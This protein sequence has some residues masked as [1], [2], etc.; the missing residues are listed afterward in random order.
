[1]GRSAEAGGSF[2]EENDPITPIGQIGGNLLKMT[3]EGLQSANAY[4]QAASLFDFSPSGMFRKAATSIPFIVSLKKA[5]RAGD[6]EAAAL[7]RH[8]ESPKGPRVS[9]T[10]D[11]ALIDKLIAHSEGALTPEQRAALE[12]PIRRVRGSAQSSV[13]MRDMGGDTFEDGVYGVRPGELQN[14]QPVWQTYNV[15]TG[16]ELEPFETM[17]GAKNAINSYHD[18]DWGAGKAR[19]AEGFQG[20]AHQRRA[21]DSARA[22]G[23]P[24]APDEPSVYELRPQKRGEIHPYEQRAMKVVRYGK[25]RYVV[26]D[27][28]NGRPLAEFD[29]PKKAQKELNKLR[30]RTQA[31]ALKRRGTMDPEK[32]GYDPAGAAA[33]LMRR[34]GKTN[35]GY[36]DEIYDAWDEAH[37]TDQYLKRRDIDPSEATDLQ[38]MEAEAYAEFPGHQYE[39]GRVP[40]DRGPTLVSGGMAPVVPFSTAREGMSRYQRGTENMSPLE[41]LYHENVQVKRYANPMDTEAYAREQ[42]WEAQK[43]KKLKKAAQRDAAKKEAVEEAG[44]VEISAGVRNEVNSVLDEMRKMG[45]I[46]ANAEMLRRAKAKPNGTAAKLL[47]IA[48]PAAK[49]AG[50]PAVVTAA[51]EVAETAAEVGT[52][53]W[54]GV[55]NVDLIPAA[56]A[57]DAAAIEVLS[58]RKGKA[59]RKAYAE[60]IEDG[61][62]VAAAADAVVPPV[63]A[64]PEI[65]ADAIVSDAVGGEDKIAALVEKAKK[66]EVSDAE[67]DALWNAAEDIGD[68]PTPVRQAINM[69]T[70]SPARVATREGMTQRKHNFTVTAPDGSQ[71]GF[72]TA[73]RAQ[74]HADKVGGTVAK[75]EKKAAQK[76][77]QIVHTPSGARAEAERPLL[78]TSG[79]VLEE[80]LKAGEGEGFEQALREMNLRPSKKAQRIVAKY[81]ADPSRPAQDVGDIADLAGPDPADVAFENAEYAESLKVPPAQAE[82]AAE[83]A[84]EAGARGV[85]EYSGMTAEQLRA[86]ADDD[87]MGVMSHILAYNER[88][89]KAGKKPSKQMKQLMDDMEDGA[90]DVAGRAPTTGTTV[91][92]AKAKRPA[93]SEYGGKTA[94]QLRPMSDTDPHGVI[95]HIEK[96]FARRKDA[97]KEPS[98]QMQKLYDELKRGGTAAPAKPVS[99]T[100]KKAK[101]GGTSYAG[102]TSEQLEPLGVEDPAGVI[103]HLDAYVA[104][105]IKQGKKPSDKM[106]KLLAKLKKDWGQG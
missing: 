29:D 50:E 24:L 61:D 91:E 52:K 75:L 97:G 77:E 30:S 47:G 106:A 42:Y 76:G 98:K 21:Q 41:T 55:D 66:G 43:L 28:A 35:E 32:E 90:G 94:E 31:S 45:D 49:V 15:K 69:G 87:Q 57:G 99:T 71:R 53:S 19:S 23:Q 86:Y 36:A 33:E 102:M 20:V 65:D 60:I 54:K 3:G 59:A 70:D 25:N 56:K 93:G 10:D 74:E 5:A 39:T 2:L 85:E 11:E 38:H 104:R 9:S 46:Q 58:T 13:Q 88:R 72:K 95:E 63:A 101:K 73:H 34:G 78:K 67:F 18:V 79:E 48:E 12:D 105:R 92:Q 51:K 103:K 14:G 100:V 81:N 64:A 82:R 1:L 16:E 40:S 26:E 17:T 8:L 96:Y 6:A 89:A 7:A 83:S 27:V 22:A 80:M 4:M 68:A 62:D 37:D 84:T 44:G